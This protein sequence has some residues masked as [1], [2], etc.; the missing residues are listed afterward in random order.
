M[1]E[2]GPGGWVVRGAGGHNC[3]GFCTSDGLV[4]DVKA[5][6]SVR[7]DTTA[8]TATVGGGANNAD[9]GAA[10]A[11]HGVYVPGGRCPT[12]GASGLTL[13][14][15]WGFSCHHLGLTCDSLRSTALVTASGETVTA[16]ASENPDLF[17]AVRG[18]AGGNFGVHTAFTYDVVP[19]GDVTVIR[20]QWSGGETAALIDAVARMQASAPRELGLRLA[21]VSQ[22]RQPPSQPSP[23][24]VNVI[25]LFWESQADAEASLAPVEQTQRA[26]ARTVTRMSFSLAREFLAAETPSGLYQVK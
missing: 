1:E 11:A 13:G 16:S 7:V 23:L 21:V 3:A 2:D 9:L 18:G 25:D 26:V 4:I 12:A 6:R 17:W 10:F 14:G 22:S 8:G 19:S 5:M 15:G 20:L 24:D